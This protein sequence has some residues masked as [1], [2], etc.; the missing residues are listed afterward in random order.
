MVANYKAMDKNGISIFL[1]IGGKFMKKNKILLLIASL[2]MA[3]SVNAKVVLEDNTVLLGKWKLYAE[4]AAL[5]K[6]KKE[7]QIKWDFKKDGTLKTSAKDPRTGPL[8]VNVTYKVE[9]GVI[10]KQVQPGMSKMETCS[11][12]KLEGKDMILKCPFLYYFLEKE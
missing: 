11:V 6:E 8:S 9:D 7:L 12:E 3:S 1:L 4:T 5:H 2:L 10:K